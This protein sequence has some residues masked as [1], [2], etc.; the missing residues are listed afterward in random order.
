MYVEKHGELMHLQ[1]L[2]S[3]KGCDVERNRTDA[4]EHPAA[5][6][7]IPEHRGDAYIC[8][9]TSADGKARCRHTSCCK[10]CENPRKVL[11]ASD[12]FLFALEQKI[13]SPQGF[14]GMELI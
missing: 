13:I 12:C 7:N 10:R 4:G 1:T 9:T 8:P 3:R 6:W 11:P 2:L 5:R 14:G